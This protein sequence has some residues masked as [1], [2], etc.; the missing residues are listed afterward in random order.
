MGWHGF[1]GT[2][3][4]NPPVYPPSHPSLGQQVLTNLETPYWGTNMNRLLLITLSILLASTTVPAADWTAAAFPIKE[5]HFGTVAVGSKTEFV[6]PV[7]NRL[8]STMHIQTVRASCGCTTPIV[9]NQ[10]IPS[11][12]TGSI[13]A[14]FNTDT[15]KGKRGATLTVVIDQPFYS[16]VQLKVDG[17]IRSDMVFHPGAIEFP[18]LNQGEKS[19]ESTKVLYAGRDDWK[20]VDVRSHQPWLMPSVKETGRGGGRV[21]YELTVD[22][23]EDAPTGYFQDELV[24]T[25]NDRGMPQVP[26]RVSGQV[27]SPLSISP[28]AITLGRLKPGESVTKKVVLLGQQPFT[29]ASITADGW[30]VKFDNSREL[31]KMHIINATFAFAGQGSGPQK[32]TLL[33]TTAGADSVTAKG[34]LIADV[35]DQ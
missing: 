26:L 11:G 10:Y 25:T 13:V 21:N 24:L 22:V 19:S 1:S 12:E 16:E 14:R 32:A 17:Y 7:V 27:E 34:L 9:A 20:I 15:F 31:K 29:I 5:H 33:I 30:E 6:F 3:G 18:K 2:P 8:S 35:R 23:R 4:A 28:Q